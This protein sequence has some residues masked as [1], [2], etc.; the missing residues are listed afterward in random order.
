MEV[1]TGSAAAKRAREETAGEVPSTGTTDTREP[2]PKPLRRSS[3]RPRPNALTE[4]KPT[5]EQP[6]LGCNHPNHPL[7][8]HY[9]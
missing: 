2:T 9:V 5:T 3:I 4:R 7:K 8:L 6:P 1:A